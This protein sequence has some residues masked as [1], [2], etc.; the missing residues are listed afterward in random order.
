MRLR[1]AI[2]AAV[3]A[4]AFG[5]SGAVI[6]TDVRTGT[7]PNGFTYY[8]QHNANPAATAD[9]FFAQRVGS[10]NED[11]DQRGLAHFLEHMCFNGTE[12]FPGNSLITYLES[13]GVKFG[14]H[15]N[16]YTST[17]ETVYNICKVPVARPSVLDSCLLILRDW[18]CALS[19]DSAGIDAERGIIVNEWR[20]RNTASNRMLERAF[21]RLYAG[22]PYGERLPIGRM[23]VVGNFPPATLRR[24]YDKWY[25]PANQAV[26][27]VGDIDV[28]AMESQIRRIFGAVP[29]RRSAAS[30]AVELTPV[31][32]ADSFTA[33][34]ESDPEQGVEM[35]QLYFRMPAAP[36]D[37][38]GAIRR[39][40]LGDMA[41][42]MLA[43]RFADVEVSPD[44]PHNSLG[45][46]EVRYL[47]SRG[48]QALTMRG[49]VK[50]GRESDALRLWYGELLRAMR[51]GFG[52]AELADA[53]RDLIASATEEA[54][55]AASAT[56]TVRARRAVRHFLDGGCAMS[57]DEWLARLKET[58]AG[59]TS[60]DIVAY[61]RSA[62]ADAPR[63]AVALL[64]RPRSEKSDSA[65][66]AE[67]RGAFA[68]TAGRA[69]EPYSGSSRTL[70]LMTEL[71]APGTLEA[72]DSLAVYGARVY[73]LSNGIRLIA[74]R[75][76]CK[77][78]QIYIRGYSPGGLSVIYDEADVPS[79]RVA[80]ELAAA[81]P[82]G[83]LSAAEMQRVLDENSVKVSASLGNTEESIE[84]SATRAGFET[85]LQAI[86]LRATAVRPDSA[87]FANFVDAQRASV[88][89][90]RLNPVQIMGDSIHY[91]IYNRHPLAAHQTLGDVDRIDLGRA[92]GAFR[93][94]F[95]DMSDFTFMIVGDF[96]T[97]SLELLAARYLASLPGGGR[98]EQARDFGYRYTPYSFQ[99]RF[100][101]PMEAPQSIV[102]SFYSGDV[103]YTLDNLL[104]ATAFGQL[105]R[106]R[107]LADL[108]EDRAWTY[109]VKAHCAVN[110]GVSAGQGAQVMMPTYIKVTPGHESETLDA[111][112][113][114][115]AA[116]AAPGGIT[117]DE[118]S[119]IRQFLIKNHEESLRDNAYW[120][121]VIKIYDRDGID[122]DT[123]FD[124][125]VGRLTPE[126]VGAF[127]R[128][129]LLPANRAALIMTPAE[130]RVLQNRRM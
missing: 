75:T 48:E 9:F 120:L 24:F 109:S 36:V 34:V 38:G 55:N 52:D 67:L 130:E 64:Y 117:D 28:D 113:A 102:Y 125:A 96:D 41:A 116:L 65:V 40:V 63:G 103:D 90:R 81:M 4:L 35:L 72:V 77:P 10:V 15:L 25:I 110:P 46:G 26:I 58:A 87:A 53:R 37:A 118:L 61:L 92:L 105:L 86:Y 29:A 45:I 59:V 39:R 99:S 93:D 83:S 17:D 27:V 43:A 32:V 68:E 106:A 108:R 112:N 128:R 7:L 57:Q 70:S 19:L 3:A 95:A 97:D 76:D 78:G 1:F 82:H 50:P 107:L 129:Y 13:I 123:G 101:R 62:A 79:L 98:R 6:D 114:T 20:Q 71:P 66:E 8:L 100:S 121:K 122:T 42:T 74:K 127:G 18:S 85:A 44:C 21:P 60:G 126:A 88:N 73:E 54:R 31:P 11:D 12:H 84:A 115:V 22:S 33:V 47:M 5:A 2:L 124:A 111:V 80:A 49:V 16:A 119:G 14:A 89:N 23:E 94:R 104:C 69:F 56:N 91:T 30:Q 51:H